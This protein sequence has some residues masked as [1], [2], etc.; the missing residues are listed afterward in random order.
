MEKK[1]LKIL[2]S[3]TGDVYRDAGIL[4]KYIFEDE[5]ENNIVLKLNL[6]KILKKFCMLDYEVFETYHD[7]IIRFDVEYYKDYCKKYAQYYA[8]KNYE[9]ALYYVNQVI[10]YFD[11]PQG[12]V[13]FE[14]KL[15]YFIYKLMFPKFKG[16]FITTG[17][18]SIFSNLADI[19]LGLKDI[20][21]AIESAKISVK[22]SP[23]Q[24]LYY[25]KLLNILEQNALADDMEI[26]LQNAYLSVDNE[27]DLSVLQYF[28]AKYYFLKKHYALAKVCAGFAM[29]KR[30]PLLYKK[31]I[32]DMMDDMKNDSFSN[33]DKIGDYAQTLDKKGFPFEMDAHIFFTALCLYGACLDGGIDDDELKN[34]AIKQLNR[35]KEFD[36]VAEYE[37]NKNAGN[38]FCLGNKNNI[39]IYFNKIWK[40]EAYTD[41]KDYSNQIF[42]LRNK[43]NFIWI[44]C[45]L[46]KNSSK[47]RK[48]LQKGANIIEQKA[49]QTIQGKKVSY[50]F[51]NLGTTVLYLDINF[52]INT[53]YCGFARAKF[54]GKQPTI[55]N[56][57]LQMISSIGV[58]S[59]Q[60]HK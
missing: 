3:L 36:F 28:W 2:D 47:H 21:K 27:I 15:K 13:S 30:V 9:M 16:Q 52:E 7:K 57:I 8:Q 23:M 55:K 33:I 51:Y 49:Y 32:Y 5:K 46:K 60:K 29:T 11:F 26:V 50:T 43:Q 6:C 48:K 31:K 41:E 56:E 24:F 4:A 35:Y 39:Y 18:A 34:E 40:V 59:T 12:D 19:C 37:K 45:F 25:E 38:D 53:K 44:D 17:E 54:S 10:W 58:F 1:I 20:D 42:V 14:N 22:C